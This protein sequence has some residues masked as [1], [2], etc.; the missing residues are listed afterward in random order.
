MTNQDFMLELRA[1]S[2]SDLMKLSEEK[3]AELFALKFQAAV[4]S[5]EQTHKLKVLK[6][7][8]AR[9]ELLISERMK[10]G[11]VK[12]IKPVKTNYSKAV[13]AADKEG[14][15]VRKKQ[16]EQV[17]QMQQ[18]QMGMSS[19][20][21]VD[22]FTAAMMAGAGMEVPT[23][24]EQKVKVAAKPVEKKAEVKSAAK[25]AAK[26]AEVKSA[27]KPVA[28]KAEVK[29]AAKPV[30]KKAEVKSAAKPA[31]K[32]VEVKSAAKP[33]AKKAEVKSAA[34]PVAK[35]AEVKS[36]AKKTETKSAG[37]KETKTPLKISEMDIQIEDNFKAI[38]VDLPKKPKDAKTY[39]FGS[40]KNLLDKELQENEKS[41]N[42]K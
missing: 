40:N 39:V 6:K 9:I 14:Q 3:R 4:G 1:K 12:K 33:V 8:I 30:A 36:A 15:A 11:E 18:D 32:K 27:A 16:I 7:D 2:T 20:G 28:K 23:A 41:K 35:K 13:K 31:A 17:Q 19:T 25:P 5:L 24:T 34:K 42:K 21:N 37:V 22:D 38:N 29:S 10:A 26:K